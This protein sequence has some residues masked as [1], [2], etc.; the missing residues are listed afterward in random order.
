MY[1]HTCIY[2][3]SISA[4][5]SLIRLMHVILINPPTPFFYLSTAIVSDSRSTSRHRFRLTVH[6]TV[7]FVPTP[8]TG[9][10]LM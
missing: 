10:T 4:D 1:T 2:I 7:P 6:I 3:N 8:Q 9:F 5:N